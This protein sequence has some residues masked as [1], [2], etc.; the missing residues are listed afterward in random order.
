MGMK[1]S[2]GLKVAN[3]LSLT[4]QLQPAIQLLQFSIL[5]L[6]LEIQIR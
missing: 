2:V 4:P 3:S 6:E 5:E 1:L